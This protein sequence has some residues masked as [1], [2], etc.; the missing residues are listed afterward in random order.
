MTVSMF[1]WSL[2][3]IACWLMV[4]FLMYIIPYELSGGHIEDLSPRRRK[5]ER[6]AWEA[7]QNRVDDNKDNFEI[8]NGVLVKYHG[9]APIVIIPNG[10]K[11]IG[12]AVFKDSWRYGL[13]EVT[14]PDSVTV[15]GEEAFKGSVNLKKVNFGKNVKYIMAYAFD[16]C[17]F[18]KNVALPEN[19]KHLGCGAFAECSDIEWVYF[20]RGLETIGDDCF[21]NCN[22]LCEKIYP[23]IKG[24]GAYAF[25][26]NDRTQ[27][28]KSLQAVYNDDWWNPDIQMDLMFHAPTAEERIKAARR[29][30]QLGEWY[31][32]FS[33]EEQIKRYNDWQKNDNGGMLA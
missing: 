15:I 13:R 29:D 16:Y 20:P 14:I 25:L 5:A 8:E 10:V 2:F 23:S 28:F 17:P 30:A 32:G 11:E 31:N 18:L 27:S 3:K 24:I 21:K 7:K 26:K 4:L 22:K 12:K 6:E 9:N 19:I 33:Y 1:L